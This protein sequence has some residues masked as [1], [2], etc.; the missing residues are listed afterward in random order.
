ME[1]KL[2]IASRLRQARLMAGLS[3]Q[4]VANLLMVHRPSVSEIEAGRRNVTAVEL[5]KLARIYGV[6]SYWLLGV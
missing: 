1:D 4:H 6:S 2:L 3:Q 5:V